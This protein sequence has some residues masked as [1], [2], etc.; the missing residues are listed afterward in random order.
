MS[1]I[2]VL[3]GGFIGLTTGMLLARDGHRVTVLERDPAAP[4]TAADAWEDWERP[5]VGQFRQLHFML[6]RWRQEMHEG[7]PEALDEVLAAGAVR[8]NP[9][10]LAPAERRGPLR[11]DDDRFETVTAR[12]PVL[13]AGLAAAAS[14]TPGLTVRRGVGV[15]GFVPGP[16]AIPGT[17]HVAGVHAADGEQ[18]PSELVVD[19]RGR[20]SRINDWL[21]EI[22]GLP[23]LEE[24]GPAGVLCL[25]RKIPPR[26][27]G[28]PGGRAPPRPPHPPL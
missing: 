7:L 24:R 17:P 23:A 27:G 18:I 16:S 10:A 4:T 22:G 8:V 9:L 25:H 13:E 3:G 1:T 6:S 12:R 11:P 20:R 21:L 2:T 5:G 15:T 28:R 14:R 19:C 26:Q